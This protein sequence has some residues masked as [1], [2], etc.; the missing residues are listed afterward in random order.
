MKNLTYKLKSIFFPLLLF[1][2]SFIGVYSAFNWLFIIRLKLLPIKE[3]AANFFLP[4]ILAGVLLYFFINPRLEILILQTENGK[5]RR[6][7]YFLVMLITVLAPTTIA[8]DWISASGRQIN[9]H[10]IEEINSQPEG[11]YY[12]LKNYYIDKS[13]AI[14][15]PTAAVGGKYNENIGFNA[16]YVIPIYP[17]IA[18][19]NKE[20]SAWLGKQYSH[21]ISNSGSEQNKVDSFSAFITASQE[22]FAAEDVQKFTYLSRIGNTNDADE[23]KKALESERKNTKLTILVASHE[24]LQA[25]YGEKPFWFCITLSGGILLVFLT[26]LFAGV[27]KKLANVI[28]DKS[29]PGY[30]TVRKKRYSEFEWYTF[31]IPS[32]TFFVTPILVDLNILIFIAMIFSGS[33]I[34]SIRI[35]DLIKWG[36]N[37]AM[38]IHNGEWWRLITGMF[39]HGGFIHLTNNICALVFVGVI[40]EPF[41]GRATYTSLY[42]ITGIIASIT[43]LWLNAGVSIG[44]SGAIMGFYGVSLALIVTRFISPDSRRLLLILIAIFVPTSLLMGFLGRADNAGH[45]GG[46]VSGLVLGL[47]YVRYMKIKNGS[48]QPDVRNSNNQRD[49]SIN[50]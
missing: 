50:I 16:Y 35:D 42:L 48:A 15:Y 4:T 32:K 6:F 23:Y 37:D 46:L 20:C 31:F 18:D 28:Y 9:L 17:T 12:T 26:L 29:Y 22:K 39:L 49:H 41:L 43:S 1:C 27:K 30:A 25:R 36:A 40:L 10:S 45:I 14:F 13:K 44:A 38:S 3:D 11:K 47:T 7:F 2:F 21:R 5:S 19:T 34:I 24:P 8:Q 33:D